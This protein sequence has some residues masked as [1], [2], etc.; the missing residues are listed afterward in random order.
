[1]SR[2][3]EISRK[4]REFKDVSL[5]FQ[6]NPVTGDLPIL[7]NV[8]AINQ[9]VKNLVQTIPGEVAFRSDIGSNA[10]DYLFEG[11]DMATESLIASEI[12]RTL[13]FNE[14]RIATERVE[15]EGQPDQ[16]AFNVNIYYK[17]VGYD[18]IY[19]V[20]FILEATR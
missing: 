11:F 6:A 10:T 9:S 13:G 16:C 19:T 1:M 14:P 12:E 8:R 18:E 5:S 3:I 2:N 15:V 17:I 20:E 4:V 7:K